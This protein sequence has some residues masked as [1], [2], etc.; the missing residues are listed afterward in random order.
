MRRTHILGALVVLFT[1]ACAGSPEMVPL[2]TAAGIP[3][4]DPTT[5][6]LRVVTRSTAVHD[7][8]RMRGTHVVYGDVETALGHAVAS[9]TVPWADAHR[10]PKN[11][12]GWEL[13]VEV[14]NADAS[15]EDDRVIF[16]LGVRATLRARAGNDYLAQTQTSCRQGGIVAP[17]KGAPIMYGCMMEIGRSLAGWLDGVDLD[18]VGPPH[19]T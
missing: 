5:V 1:T 7:P 18:A 13:F 2:L 9:A 12:E 19:H 16:S 3:L 15:Y 17:D 14:T 6:P 10:D 11:G 8:L 4:T